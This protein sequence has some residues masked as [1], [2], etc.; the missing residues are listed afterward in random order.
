M[1][2]IEKPMYYG[3]KPEVFELARM[4]RKRMTHPEELLWQRVKHNQIGGLRFRR[5]HPIS[6]FIADF[7]CHEARLVIEI[8]GGIHKGKHEFDDNRSAEMERYQ[9]KVIRFKNDEVENHLDEVLKIIENEVRI[10][11]QSPPL[12][13]PPDPPGGM[14]FVNLNNDII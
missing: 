6:F 4:L 5:Q 10:R 14:S 7:Y 12:F 1:E 3:A 2:E 13:S 11:I 9:I 8:D